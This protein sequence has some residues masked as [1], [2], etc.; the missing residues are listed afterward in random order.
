MQNSQILEQ[1]TCENQEDLGCGNK[2]SHKT[3]KSICEWKK[4]IH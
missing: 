3:Q 2:V 1:N 4:L